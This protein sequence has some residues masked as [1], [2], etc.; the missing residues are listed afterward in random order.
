LLPYIEENDLYNA[1]VI[2]KPVDDKANEEPRKR[3][4]KTYENP[5]DPAFKTPT[6]YGGSSYLF[7]AGTQFSLKDNDGVLF[8]ESK[9]R[10]T[11]VQDGTS[12]TLLAG[13]TLRGDKTDKADVHRQHVR[14]KEDAL[15][16]LGE[17]SGVKDFADGKNIATDR[18]TSWAEGRFLQG[19]FTMTRKI[20]DEKPDVDCGGAGGLSGMRS[21]THSVNL[22][23]CDGSVRPVT[24]AAG[25]EFLK[26]IAT[27]SGGEA[28]QFP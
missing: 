3:R 21:L 6:T 1:I 15:K 7:S 14:L 8:A 5:Q 17:D 26:A 20:N 16:G 4:V 9:I 2:E 22:L 11:D 10:F 25:T 24:D 23:F 28:V 13:E 18:C 27:R 19:T 12:N